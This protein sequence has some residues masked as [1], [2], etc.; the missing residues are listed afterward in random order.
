MNVFVC[1]NAIPTERLQALGHLEI[2][3][4]LAAAGADG[5]E[6]RKELLTAEDSLEELGALC[7]KLNLVAYYSA[8]EFLFA[9]NHQLNERG[10]K[11]LIGEAQEL[12]AVL[13]K[14]PLG[15][16][17]IKETN[18]RYVNELLSENWA[19]EGL[20]ITIE[21][22]QTPGGGNLQAITDFLGRSAALDTPIGMTF[23]T[24]NWL[25]TGEEPL[26]A[27]R[28]LAEYVSYVHLKQV[29]R[30]NEGWVTEPVAVPLLPEVNELLEKFNRNCP[31]AI[32]FPIT[33]ENAATYI[34]LMKIEQEVS[35]ER[36]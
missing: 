12:G 36:A 18:M 34:S 17:H 30:V 13:L 23:D 20:A 7:R 1:M 5:I 6:I 11:R 27:A 22:D 31:V 8:P 14:V 29:K 15:S 32:E 33:L 28:E 25:Y 19:N 9:S 4:R 10:F 24:G 35:H 3:K 2:I 16:Y 26:L 21:N